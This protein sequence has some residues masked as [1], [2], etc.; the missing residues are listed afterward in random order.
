MTD[1]PHKTIV[2]KRGVRGFELEPGLLN[3]R[4]DIL[5][6]LRT[7]RSVV[8][9]EIVPPGPDE[10][11]LASIM[12]AACRVP[13]HGKL[14]PW[15]FILMRGEECGRFAG[16]LRRRWRRLKEDGVEVLER[17][18]VVT[19]QA[20]LVV[21]VVSRV[22]KHPKIPEWEQ[23]LSAGAA[24]QNLLL[25][26]QAAGFAAHWRTGWPAYDT[27]VLRHLGLEDGER[28]AA[29]IHIGTRKA[30][31]PMLTDRRRPFWR[32]LTTAYGEL[33]AGKPADDGGGDR[34]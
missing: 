9:A 6:F 13:D 32:D 18:V 15:R 8:S 1:L 27:E 26:A 4:S 22:V 16:F 34:A 23:R 20:P 19:E 28:V 7:R 29:F 17:P 14:T 11:T 3:D 33:V 12:E 25:A 10:A 5:R 24:C 2:S 30:D 21:T 31:A